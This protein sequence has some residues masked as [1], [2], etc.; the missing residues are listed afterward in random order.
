MRAK[1]AKKMRKFVG[2]LSKEIENPPQYVE[3]E[4][5]GE[6]VVTQAPVFRFDEKEIRF[7]KIRKGIPLQWHPMSER[8][9]YRTM[10][11]N[12]HGLSLR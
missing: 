11:K 4:V 12:Y 1:L 5:Q 10:K 6:K 7:R 3:H 9:L 2:H 8:G